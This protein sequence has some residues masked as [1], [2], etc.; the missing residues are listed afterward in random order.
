MGSVEA[1]RERQNHFQSNGGQHSA[2]DNHVSILVRYSHKLERMVGE[3]NDLRSTKQPKRHI[4]RGRFED[5]VPAFGGR[6]H[7]VYVSHMCIIFA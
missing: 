2:N 1:V 6:R 4:G 3:P 5:G 7:E